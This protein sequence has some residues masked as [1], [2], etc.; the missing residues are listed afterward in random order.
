MNR[1]LG[2]VA[3]VTG[4]AMGI[5]KACA[6]MLA[7]EGAM[8]V[9]TDIDAASGGAVAGQIERENGKAIFVKHDVASESDWSVVMRDTLATFGRLD[10]LVNNAGIGT[11]GTIEEATL[12]AWRHLMS[13]NCDGVFLGMRYA[14]AAMKASGG[15]SIVNLSSILGLVGDGVAAAYCSSKGAVR[16]MSKSAALHCAKSGYKIRV[17]SVHPGY[18]ETPMVEH[19]LDLAAERRAQTLKDI[20]ALHPLG[21]IGDASDVAYGVL[22]LS[23]DES[24]FVTGS[25]LVI[26]GGYT[27]Q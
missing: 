19:F 25:E 5:G 22:Y 7:R 23:S 6:L 15:G 17:N 14:I 26:D 3:I 18:I 10:V 12:E 21:H 11:V 16:L 27:A 24:K 4:G 1:V 9:V 2:K 20:E 8:V 13:I